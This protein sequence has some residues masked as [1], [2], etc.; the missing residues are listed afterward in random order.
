MTKPQLRVL[1]IVLSVLILVVLFAGLDDLPRAQRNEIASEQQSLATAAKQLQ[2][3]QGEVTS[4]LRAEPGLFRVRAMD[5]T[6]PARLNRSAS[7]LR[8][9]QR[10][11]EQLGAFAKAN[12]RTDREK[13][14]RLLREEKS[15]RANAVD[16]AS[17][18][19]TEARHWID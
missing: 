15:L 3:A 16:E 6:L 8:T 1:A 17:A 14:E 18:V 9:A 2:K 7:S 13:V 11:M 12:R 5:T 19:Q 10:D 4:D